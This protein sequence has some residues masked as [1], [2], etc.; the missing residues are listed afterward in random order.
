MTKKSN[1]ASD[2]NRKLKTTPIAIVGLSAIFPQAHNVDE[3]WDNILNKVNCITDVPASRWSLED[4][5]D[6]DPNT[7]DKSYCKR[8]GFIPDIDFDPME[9][10]LPPNI[11]EVT[12]VSQLLALVAAKA[13]LEDA[14]YGESRDFNRELTGVILGVVGMSSKLVQPLLS[15]LQAPVWEKVLRSAGVPEGD[16]ATIVE[17]FK[18]AYVGWEENAFPGTIVNV[19][20]GRICNRFDLGGTNCVIDA[21]CA[22]SLAAVRMAVMELTEGRADMMI[23]GGVDVDNSI[24]TYLCFSKTPAFSKGEVVKAFDAGADG[25]MAGEG[26]GMLVLKRLADAERDGDRIYAT[27]RGIGSSSDGRFKSIYAPRSE[28]QA[29]ALRRAYED[30]GFAPATVGIV[31]AHGTGTMAGDPAEFSGLNLVFGED[32]PRRQYIGLGSIKSQIAHT[33]S[34]AGAASLIKMTLALHH[35]VLPATLNV[36]QPN[37][38]LE[39]ENTPF[40]LSTETRPWIR[41]EGAPPRRAGVSAFGF[42]GTNHHVVL[43][44]YAADHAEAYRRNRVPQMILLDAPTQA[45]L[46]AKSQDTLSGLQ[47]ENGPVLFSELGQAGQEREI[48]LNQARI[49]FV[50]ESREEAISLLQTAIELMQDRAQDEAWESPKGIFYRKSGIDPRGKVVALFPGQGAQYVEM[51]KELAVNFPIVRQAFA[52]MDGLFLAEGAQPLSD[53]LFPIPVFDPK[54]REAQN[55]VVTQTQNAQPAIGTLS[56]ALYQILQQGGFQPDFCAGHSFGELTALWASGVVTE[57]DYYAL[58]KARGKAMAPPADPTFDAGTMLAVKGDVEKIRQEIASM[59]G[60]TLANWNSKNQVVLAGSKL[61]MTQAQQALSEKGFSAIPLSVSAAFHTPLVGHAQ[62]PFAEVIAQTPFQKPSVRVFSNSTGQ[63]HS[64]DPKAIQQLL[65]DHILNPVLWKAEIEAIYAAGGYFFVECGPKNILTNLVDNIL[66]E[67]PHIAV[68]LNASPKKDS[69]RQLREA[70]VKLKVAGLHLGRIDPFQSRVVTA[71]KKRSAVTVKLNGGL[72]VS[73]KT[74][75]GFEKALNDGFKLVHPQPVAPEPVKELAAAAPAPVAVKVVDVPAPAP[76]PVVAAAPVVVAAPSGMMNAVEQAL[77]RLQT[78]QSEAT[79][80]HEQYLSN[81]SEYGRIFT[82]VTQMGVSLVSNPSANSQQIDQ[83]LSALQSIE[84]SM[85]RFHDHQAETLRAHEQYLKSQEEFAQ[86][87]VGLVR[88]QVE[89]FKGAPPVYMPAPVVQPVAVV[90]PQAAAVA[91]AAPRKPL[92]EVRK[93]EP[94]VV[95]APPVAVEKPKNGN[96]H[97]KAVVETPTPV[98]VVPP[99]SGAQGDIQHALL[100]VVSEKTGYP[101]EMLDLTMDMEADLGIDSIKR[102][103]ILGA[104]RAIYPDLPKVAAEDFGEMRTLTQVIEHIRKTLPTQNQ[105]SEVWSTRP[106]L[107]QQTSEVSPTQAQPVDMAKT[108]LAVV[109]EK[110]GYPTEMLELNMDMEADLGIDSIKKVEIMGAMRQQYPNLPKAD[111]E[112]FAEARTLGQVVAYLGTL[113][114]ATSAPF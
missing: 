81:D 48:P 30:A 88:A 53:R 36:T 47:A 83:A 89:A 52:R 101:P 40:Y 65:C 69:D 66:A 18:A 15:R 106:Q 60:V 3:Y 59:P 24:L 100:G 111:P 29:K 64:D 96:G 78:Q 103:E 104:M 62:K 67:Q 7:P 84:R 10:G 79:R 58:A 2:A 50:A 46:V 97:A 11:L 70:V 41:P 14:G 110:T 5:Y 44:E 34:T 92:E 35:K 107:A 16:I 17:K 23:T 74:R 6:P 22:S 114:E 56:V 55:D 112:A 86:Q 71:P 72:F 4:Y 37:P 9:F 45:M 99:V 31:E 19:I 95:I 109:S 28:G 21:A 39:I 32:N 90:Q 27:I 51:G 98:V 43:E 8:G 1:P 76:A 25:M 77:A 108:L 73:E 38:K 80:V 63:E 105:T 13:A 94:Q 91:P 68:A 49:G 93:L 102:V 87:Y 20:A 82:Q 75:R 57:K 26:I 113:A 12:D 33:K 61:V 85:M 42:G 54:Q